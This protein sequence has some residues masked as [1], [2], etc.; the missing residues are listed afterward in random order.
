MDSAAAFAVDTEPVSNR[1][2]RFDFHRQSPRW[3]SLDL[4]CFTPPRKGSRNDLLRCRI[5]M[6]RVG[7][8]TDCLVLASSQTTYT[9]QQHQAVT[10]Q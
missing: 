6:L 3:Q 8:L 10:K 9:E 4:S 1:S 5:Y 2:S 7:L